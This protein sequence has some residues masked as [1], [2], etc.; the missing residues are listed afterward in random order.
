MNAPSD[1]NILIKVKMTFR[2][3]VDKIFVPCIRSHANIFHD[4]INILEVFY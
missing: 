4:Y 1:I 2:N 3:N